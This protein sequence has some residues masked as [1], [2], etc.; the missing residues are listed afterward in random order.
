MSSIRQAREGDT[1]K[2]VYNVS[3]SL[4]GA[5]GREGGAPKRRASGCR[6]L[7]C[8]RLDKAGAQ[9]SKVMSAGA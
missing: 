2:V 9:S 5:P 6:F 4:D 7:Y 3:L 8:H 1:S